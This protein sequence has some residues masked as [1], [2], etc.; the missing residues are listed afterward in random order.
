MPYDTISQTKGGGA[1][2]S[3]LSAPMP[4]AEGDL[5]NLAVTPPAQDPPATLWATAVM[6]SV[7][8]SFVGNIG[9]QTSYVVLQTGFG[10]GNWFDVAWCGP[11][12]VSGTP[13]FWL[14]GTRYAANALQQNRAVGSAPSPLVGFNNIGL[15]GQFRFVGK[16][17][18]S[19]STS[20]SSASLAPGVL[21]GVYVTIK[22]RLDGH[23]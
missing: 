18:V 4:A 11:T 5:W 2:Y 19:Y 20:S 9:S 7:Q 6:A 22:Y 13:L 3:T 14:S 17:T 21:P 16:S 8:F 10:D 1:G 15:L 12:G 23:R